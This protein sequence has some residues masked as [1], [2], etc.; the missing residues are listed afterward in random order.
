MIKATQKLNA[1]DSPSRLFYSNPEPNPLDS[2]PSVREGRLEQLRR[3]DAPA[4]LR[5]C[6]GQMCPAPL[7]PGC[8]QAGLGELPVPLRRGMN[9]ERAGSERGTRAERRSE[10]AGAAGSGTRAGQSRAGLGRAGLALGAGGAPAASRAAGGS[11][12][13]RRER[14]ERSPP[15]AGAEPAGRC[16]SPGRCRPSWR[17]G[18]AAGTPSRSP[19]RGP[20]P[21]RRSGCSCCRGRGGCARPPP[22][23]CRRNCAPAPATRRPGRWEPSRA[24]PAGRGL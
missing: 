23:R 6:P 16:P 21:P 5:M 1:S 19:W 4:A 9:G 18:R 2:L 15:G 12:G 3:S 14:R 20:G 22:S 17:P 13:N 11:G 10:G 7:C 8:S 24:R